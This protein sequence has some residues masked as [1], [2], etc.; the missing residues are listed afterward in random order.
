MRPEDPR[1]RSCE[2]FSAGSTGQSVSSAGDGNLPTSVVLPV[3]G[4]GIWALEYGQ[5]DFGRPLQRARCPGGVP[6]VEDGQSAI[7]DGDFD[8]PPP[9]VVEGAAASGAAEA[10]RCALPPVG[11]RREGAGTPRTCCG[12]RGTAHADPP[13]AG[14]SNP[15]A[16]SPAVAS[17]R[18]RSPKASRQSSP[19][20]P[21]RCT[22]LPSARSSAE[23]P[24]IG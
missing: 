18:Q 15:S 7:R 21:P 17:P 6:E 24:P 19:R 13:S 14:G 3:G 8:I 4:R 22:R 16:L 11:A 10:K 9:G 5:R 20:G 2:W 12:R 23:S 1:P